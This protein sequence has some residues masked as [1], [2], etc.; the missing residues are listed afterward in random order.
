MVL[1][2]V[3]TELSVVTP[4]FRQPEWLRLC[5]LSVADQTNA[6]VEHIVQDAGSGA[7][8]V[9][10]CSAFPRVELVQEPDRG[11]Y[12]AVNR[13]LRRSRG[14]ICAYLNCDE[15]YLPGVAAKV[16]DYFK[17]HPEVDVAFGDVVVVSATGGYVCSR[18]ALV[19]LR[20]HTAVCQLNT[21]SGATFFRREVFEKRGCWFDS[22]WRNCGDAE[23]ILRLLGQDVR[24][25]TLG[26]YTTVFTE[27]GENLNLTSE[28]AAE[29]RRLRSNESLVVRLLAPL[30]VLHHRLRRVRYGH[31]RPVPFNLQFYHGGETTRSSMS[32]DRP[33]A[34]WRTRLRWLR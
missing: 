31:Y 2:H 7:A 22:S 28:G 19:P 26:F 27:T 30:W 10:V 16:S 29:A 6:S 14:S 15:Q 34:V 3:A 33:V 20:Y 13:G 5:L 17:T 32:V 12:D 23:W 4:S 9:E 24:F 8:V 21:F 18:Q 25:A 11:M 1:H